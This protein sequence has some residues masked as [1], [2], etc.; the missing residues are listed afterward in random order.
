MRALALLIAL[1]FGGGNPPTAGARGTVTAWDRTRVTVLEHRFCVK[2]GTGW[3]YASCA[4]AVRE[5][6]ARKLCHEQGLGDHPY[7]LQL[8]D[9]TPSPERVHCEPP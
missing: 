7:L 3:D 6:V 4:R 1:G 9:D 8:G 2:V 5:R